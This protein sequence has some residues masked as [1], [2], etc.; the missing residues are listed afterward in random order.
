MKSETASSK[1]VSFGIDKD[2]SEYTGTPDI[3]AISLI[4][5]AMHRCPICSYVKYSL[6]KWT[7]S[8]KVSV[9]A[10][11]ISLPNDSVMR[12][13]HQDFELIILDDHSSD[14]SMNRITEYVSKLSRDQQKKVR[15]LR[16]EENLGLS[17]SCNKVLSI[18]RGKYVIRVDSDDVL[19]PDAI[20][21]MLAKTKIE[22]TSGCLTGFYNTKEKLTITSETLSNQWHPAGCLLST[23]HVNELKYKEGLEY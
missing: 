9:V 11:T 7:L 6:L 19:S 10:R 17:K 23:W 12:Q 8:T 4:D 15:I 16:N 21:R 14:D 2:T 3:A 5:A 22:D 20:E 13:S 18:C 1:R